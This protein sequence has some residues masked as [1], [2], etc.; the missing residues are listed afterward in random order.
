[1]LSINEDKT[2]TFYLGLIKSPQIF[3]AMMMFNSG[4]SNANI[5]TLITIGRKGYDLSEEQYGP[6]KSL[7][8]FRKNK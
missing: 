1:M 3:F 5:N 2:I 4:G 6:L 8:L 7:W